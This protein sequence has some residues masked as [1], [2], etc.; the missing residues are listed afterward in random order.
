MERLAAIEGLECLF[1]RSKRFELTHVTVDGSRSAEFVRE[2]F[3]DVQVKEVHT[4]PLFDF[5]TNDDEAISHAPIVQ[6]MV[7][8]NAESLFLAEDSSTSIEQ[9][10]KEHNINLLT[11]PWSMQSKLE[12]KLFFQELLE[13]CGIAS[14]KTWIIRGEEDIAHV[15]Q[16]PVVIQHPAV[17]PPF[18][19]IVVKDAE[20]LH[21]IV[22]EK[23]EHL[24]FVCRVFADGMP[25]G[26]SIIV[27]EHETIFSSVRLQCFWEGTANLQQ[28]LGVQW[29]PTVE[30]AAG[31]VHN[32]EEALSIL[33]KELRSI[34]FRGI[35]NVD[36]IADGDTPLFLECNPRMSAATPCLPLEPSL[37]HGF[38]LCEEFIRAI[39][40]EH[41]S[42]NKET[43]PQSKFEG[44]LIQ[45][46]Y[47]VPLM[48]KYKGKIV[49][50]A[51]GFYVWDGEDITLRKGQKEFKED[52][53]MLFYSGLPASV[54]PEAI[55][56]FG[57]LITNFAPFIPQRNGVPVLST[58]GRKVFTV[59]ENKFLGM[60]SK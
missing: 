22:T 45:F 56:H 18:K 51:T 26:V 49:V 14:P 35:A 60:L 19:L 27:G 42:D 40:M 31:F 15:D 24:P 47:L 2:C 28:F 8:C 7:S 50:P 9:W 48:Q 1:S 10:G 6:A 30:L 11:T 3:P 55:R 36:L 17:H 25:L 37:I 58:E 54:V 34:G 44:S 21:H 53:E 23:E 20:E 5:L 13:R 4:E 32:L 57:V 41:L 39:N 38:D 29:L 59:M 43:I 16:F 12:N 46:D 52:R 33:A